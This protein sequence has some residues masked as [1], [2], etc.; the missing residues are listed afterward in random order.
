MSEN[1]RTDGRIVVAERMLADPSVDPRF[2]ISHLLGRHMKSLG[3][4]WK[5]MNGGLIEADFTNTTVALNPA[6]TENGPIENGVQNA[7]YRR[8]IGILRLDR[9]EVPFEEPALPRP[10]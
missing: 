4:Y 8:Y 1:V 6:H 10:A 9:N 2:A 5:P 3:K 7:Q